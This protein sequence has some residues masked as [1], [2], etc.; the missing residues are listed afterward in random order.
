ME[1]VLL[2]VIANHPKTIQDP[3]PFARVSNADS[4]MEAMR[5]TLLL[6]GSLNFMALFFGLRRT[7]HISPA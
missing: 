4:F 1:Q 7:R 2:E 3:A 6:F 5:W